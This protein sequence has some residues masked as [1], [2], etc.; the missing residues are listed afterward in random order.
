[1]V[2]NKKLKQWCSLG[3]GLEVRKNALYC[4]YCR[5][6]VHALH[7]GHVKQ[8]RYAIFNLFDRLQM[9]IP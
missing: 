8:V 9:K 1:M 3:K 7:R 4:I 5:Q 2:S 6:E